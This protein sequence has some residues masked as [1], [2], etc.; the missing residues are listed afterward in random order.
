M[1]RWGC[2]VRKVA[3]KIGEGVALL[4]CATIAVAVVFG[5]PVG[6]LELL[7]YIKSLEI[8]WLSALVC[9]LL[10]TGLLVLCILMLRDVVRFFRR[11]IDSCRVK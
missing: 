6:L 9:G 8:L 5:I 10:L 1:V 3:S 11:T 7:L 2:V 4:I